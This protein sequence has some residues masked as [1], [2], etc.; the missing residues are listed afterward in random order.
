MA[1]APVP[2]GVRRAAHLAQGDD[3]RFGQEA[4]LVQIGTKRAEYA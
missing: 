4:P 2:I 1:A 3:E